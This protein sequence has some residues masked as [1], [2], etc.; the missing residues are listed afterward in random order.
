MLNAIQDLQPTT[1]ADLDRSLLRAYD[2]GSQDADL[3]PSIDHD[4]IEPLSNEPVAI[5][6]YENNIYGT[7]YGRGLYRRALYNGTV[8]LKP[9]GIKY[10]LDLYTGEDWANQ[11]KSDE[12]MLIVHEV[13]P[14]KDSVCVYSWIRR[15]DAARGVK[16]PVLG[17]CRLDT[18][19]LELRLLILDDDEGVQGTWCLQGKPCR[20]GRA[21]TKSPQILAANYDLS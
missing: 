17:F 10:L 12:Q 13:D 1:S 5:R 21:G 6:L 19:T 16:T 18:Q 11:A 20:A 9:S 2:P 3:N 15:Y 8:D 14:Y 7:T 4:L